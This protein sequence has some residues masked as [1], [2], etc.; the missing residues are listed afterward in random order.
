MTQPDTHHTTHTHKD[1][2][3]AT[4]SLGGNGQD[5]NLNTKLTSQTIG[6]DPSPQSTLGL[7]GMSGQDPLIL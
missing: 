3:P 4:L 2:S 1:N 6:V 5:G 7:W